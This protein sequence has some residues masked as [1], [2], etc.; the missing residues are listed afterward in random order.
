MV[1][2]RPRQR[3]TISVEASDVVRVVVVV[4]ERREGRR[5][6]WVSFAHPLALI[7]PRAPRAQWTTAPG[8]QMQSG[9][10]VGSCIASNAR[11]VPPTKAAPL[12]SSLRATIVRCGGNSNCATMGAFRSQS[13]SGS[14]GAGSATAAPTGEP[15][16]PC[17]SNDRVLRSST[18]P[19]LCASMKCSGMLEDR[20]DIVAS[21]TALV[22]VWYTEFRRNAIHRVG[23]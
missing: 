4:D 18:G 17:G 5:S 12:G 13:R 20:Q 23:T 2:G 9:G 15:S 16:N 7:S 11:S 19:G 21:Y 22:V 8:R 1:G 10:G 6:C 3:T 14:H